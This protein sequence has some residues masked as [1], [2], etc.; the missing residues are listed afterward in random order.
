MFLK[1]ATFTFS[2]LLLT[3]NFASAK[4]P[5]LVPPCVYEELKRHDIVQTSKPS[6]VKDTIKTEY[7]NGPNWGLKKSVC[8][9]AGYSLDSVID[10]EVLLV[11]FEIKEKWRDE[12]LE[13]WAVTYNQSCLCLYKTV[14]KN[15]AMAP[16][17]MSVKKVKK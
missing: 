5:Y 7:L 10:K 8:E 14:G 17:I 1:K 12:S 15:S 9:D 16:G 11:N 2:F 13:V 3:F 4:S 6:F